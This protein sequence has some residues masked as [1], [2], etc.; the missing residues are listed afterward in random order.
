MFF[1][2]QKS[3]EKLFILALRR[4][5][6]LALIISLTFG[7]SVSYAQIPIGFNPMAVL[8]APGVMVSAT[9]AFHPAV[10]K[11]IKIFPDNPLRFDFIID[12]VSESNDKCS[13]NINEFHRHD[14][15]QVFKTVSTSSS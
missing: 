15:F 7:P 3:K 1:Y 13:A 5:I 12:T 11:G 9:N 4:M 14:Q 6:A 2:Y 8:P 10:V